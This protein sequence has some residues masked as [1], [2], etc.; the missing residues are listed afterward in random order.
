M[1]PKGKLTDEKKQEMFDAWKGSAE[2]AAIER[3]IQKRSEIPRLELSVTDIS[4]NLQPYLDAM[5]SLVADLKVPGRK[6]KGMF[7]IMNLIS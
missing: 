2:Y 7:S 6:A 3:F 4:Y 1:G 5:F